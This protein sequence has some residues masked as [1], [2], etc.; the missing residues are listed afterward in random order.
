MDHKTEH[1][2]PFQ[3]LILGMT[4]LLLAIHPK[5]VRF[6]SQTSEVEELV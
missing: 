1:S 4:V 2:L 6:V 3:V 5:T